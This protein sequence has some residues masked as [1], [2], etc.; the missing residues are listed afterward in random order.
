MKTKNL[1]IVFVMLV[2][3]LTTIS[4]TEEEITPGPGDPAHELIQEENA[5]VK[6]IHS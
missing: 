4:C 6:K 5:P 1:I 2:L 3:S